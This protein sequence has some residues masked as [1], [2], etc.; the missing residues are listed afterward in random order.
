MA[1]GLALVT[2]IGSVHDPSCA[3]HGAGEAHG[4]AARPVGSSV[5]AHGDPSTADVHLE[6]SAAAGHGEH[7]SDA[8]QHGEDSGCTCPGG[9]CVLS[10]SAPLPSALPVAWTFDFTARDE[11]PVAEISLALGLP[12]HTLPPGTGPPTSA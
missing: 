1:V 9:L 5:H 12:E 2:S 10:A 6:V 11:A 7:S 8:A 4:G 3:H